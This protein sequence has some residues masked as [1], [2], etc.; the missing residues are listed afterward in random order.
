MLVTLLKLRNAVI[1]LDMTI[2]IS[3]HADHGVVVMVLMDI[4]HEA[5]N[6]CSVVFN[7]A[8]LNV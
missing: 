8:L 1:R 4:N 7:F 5:E 2:T 3:F 6:G